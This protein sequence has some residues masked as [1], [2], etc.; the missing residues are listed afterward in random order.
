MAGMNYGRRLR[1]ALPP[2]RLVDTEDEAL[3]WLSALSGA[4]M[5]PF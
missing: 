2:M 3:A 1:E 4:A 5:L